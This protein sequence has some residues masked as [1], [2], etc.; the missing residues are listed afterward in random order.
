MTQPKAIYYAVTKMTTDDL[1]T[2]EL[3]ALNI[4]AQL[5]IDP[6]Q[7]EWYPKCANLFT[8]AQGSKMHSAIKDAL[9]EIV[10]ERLKQEEA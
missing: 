8:E 7:R 6:R 1:T 5:G 2:D 10:L 4:H 3:A 9:A